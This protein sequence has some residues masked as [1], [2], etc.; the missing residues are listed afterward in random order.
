MLTTRAVLSG[1][2]AFF[3]VACSVDPSAPTTPSANLAVTSLAAVDLAATEVLALPSAPTASQPVAL[4]G[5]FRNNGTLTVQNFGWS[6]VVDGVVRATGTVGL[7]VK[8]GQTITVPTNGHYLG[9]LGPGA[10]SITFLVD[11]KNAIGDAARSNNTIS[12]SVIVSAL[13][14]GTPRSITIGVLTPQGTPAGGRI[15]MV[16]DGYG[17]KMGTTNSAG[18]AKLSVSSSYLTI[19]AMDP[20]A[21]LYWP[22]VD[23][24]NYSATK[25]T[26]K[27]VSP[28]TPTAA[29]VLYEDIAK[30]LL[31]PAWKTGTTLY[32]TY[33]LLSGK[34]PIG[35]FRGFGMFGSVPSVYELSYQKYRDAAGNVHWGLLLRGNLVAPMLKIMPKTVADMFTPCVG[36]TIGA[37][38]VCGSVVG[39]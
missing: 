34:T 35:P 14:P 31:Q 8:P 25:Y 38:P 27:L 12:R 29:R 7:A 9:L 18:E 13:S 36:G 26:V 4:Y 11:T 1:L 17:V 39:M 2:A 5:S 19:V 10:H 16:Q 20:L 21:P 24:P 6:L 3:L 37:E 28:S 22:A 30:K 32:T 15:V 23:V 33:T